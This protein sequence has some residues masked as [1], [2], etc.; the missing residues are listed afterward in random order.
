MVIITTAGV[1]NYNCLDF[2][3][4]LFSAE[5]STPL[6]WRFLSGQIPNLHAMSRMIRTLGLDSV[7]FSFP[8]VCGKRVSCECRRVLTSREK[9]ESLKANRERPHASSL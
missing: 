5:P 6:A 1:K 7:N 8:R 9:A 3:K 4:V 2:L